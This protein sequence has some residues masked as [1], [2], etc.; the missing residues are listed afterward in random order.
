[1]KKKNKPKRLNKKKMLIIVIE[2]WTHCNAVDY[3]K[4]NIREQ[5]E[6]WVGGRDFEVWTRNEE[7]IRKKISA[8]DL[9]CFKVGSLIKS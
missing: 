9:N 3:D 8:G 6:I 2:R 5:C 4:V 1:M 7:W